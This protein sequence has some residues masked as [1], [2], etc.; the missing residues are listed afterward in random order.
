MGR[1]ASGKPFTTID[2]SGLGQFLNRLQRKIEA[3]NNTYANAPQSLELDYAKSQVAAVAAAVKALKEKILPEFASGKSPGILTWSSIKSTMEEV[4]K[5]YLSVFSTPE[6]AVIGAIKRNFDTLCQEA[7]KAG[8]IKKITP[9]TLEA[10]RLQFKQALRKAKIYEQALRIPGMDLESILKQVDNT[11]DEWDFSENTK[12]GDFRDAL[13]KALD[14]TFPYMFYVSHPMSYDLT[15]EFWYGLQTLPE[16]IDELFSFLN[17]DALTIKIPALFSATYTPGKEPE[18][19]YIFKIESHGLSSTFDLQFLLSSNR[20]M[21]DSAIKVGLKDYLERI[22]DTEEGIAEA[23]RQSD[24]Q[25]R[26]KKAKHA[27][28]DL[29]EDFNKQFTE[30]SKPLSLQEAAYARQVDVVHERIRQTEQLMALAQEFLKKLK[31]EMANVSVSGPADEEAIPEFFL[32]NNRLELVPARLMM[33]AEYAK[34]IKNIEEKQQSLQQLHSQL[35]DNIPVI[36]KAWHENELAFH[37]E[38]RDALGM[39]LEEMN[40]SLNQFDAYNPTLELPPDPDGQVLALKSE[41]EKLGGALEQLAR[42][43]ETVGKLAAIP[44]RDTGDLLAFY[45]ALNDEIKAIYKS[46]Q[47]VRAA[48]SERI[49]R[50]QHGLLSRCEKLAFQL[51]KAQ[52]ALAFRESMRSTNLEGIKQLLAQ[53]QKQL[54]DAEKQLKTF[55][56]DAIKTDKSISAAE[57]TKQQHEKM[58][59]ELQKNRNDQLELAKKSAARLAELIQNARGPVLSFDF[60]TPNEVSGFKLAVE[61]SGQTFKDAFNKYTEEP[62]AYPDTIASD[63]QVMS[64]IDRCFMSTKNS[65][66]FKAMMGIERFKGRFFDSEKVSFDALL[67]F[68]DASTQ[69][70]ESLWKFK[71]QQGN[72]DINSQAYQEVV[73]LFNSLL[74]RKRE[75][76]EKK[77][78]VRELALAWQP[79]DTDFVKE[80][81]HFDRINQSLSLV[82]Q[83]LAGSEE[84]LIK[85][86]KELAKLNK[87]KL[88]QDEGI[89]SSQEMIATLKPNVEIVGLI[90]QLTEGIT[91][92]G[93]A[94]RDKDAEAKIETLY[95]QYHK[96]SKVY[97]WLLEKLK[98]IPN[99]EDYVSNQQNINKQLAANLEQLQVL[100]RGLIKKQLESIQSTATVLQEKFAKDARASSTRE[101]ET[102]PERLSKA[103]SILFNFNVLFRDLLELQKAEKAFAEKIEALNDSEALKEYK[104][105]EP[106]KAVLEE[107]EASKQQ[108]L[109]DNKALLNEMADQLELYN[110]SLKFNYNSLAED[111]VQEEQR[112][113]IEAY[114]NTID[115]PLKAFDKTVSQS[116]FKDDLQESLD[117]VHQSISTLNKN[118]TDNKEVL[119]GTRQRIQQRVRSMDEFTQLFNG[120]KT[121]RAK[122][123][124]FKDSIDK[125]DARQREQYIDELHVKLNNFKQRGDLSSLD[126]L[127]QKAESG[128]AD[129]HGWTLRPM[130]RRLLVVLQESRQA[131]VEKQAGPVNDNDV[132]SKKVTKGD[133]QN[134]LDAL[135]SRI[136]AMG[137]YAQKLKDKRPEH[138][139]NAVTEVSSQLKKRLDDFVEDKLEGENQVTTE[140]LT[141]FTKEMRNILRSQDDTMHSERS[142]LAPIAANIVA[143]LF[144]LGI[145]LGIKLASSKLTQ[146]YAT[147]FMSKSQREKNVDDVDEA[148]T[149]LAAPAA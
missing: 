91:Q 53:K 57:S 143:G 75:S 149:Q 117:K 76:L 78:L 44:V 87:D 139:V 109:K 40:T 128:C 98:D 114:L 29:T 33:Q 101:S 81:D 80:K 93:E 82:S 79:L 108:L 66:N 144:T 3:L 34:A 103:S 10:F 1:R 59:P 19:H 60:R 7:C 5:K 35:N 86:E 15:T 111:N 106:L 112:K 43:K 92:L 73:F 133:V 4:S 88:K 47:D 146:G 68:L 24:K 105:E 90:I 141:S 126:E 138:V 6:H 71:Q 52:S 13:L 42:D 62:A 148:L 107:S 122:R 61:S 14:V 20:G 9:N 123:F 27:L 137:A 145:A 56:E 22:A 2:D 118:I 69:E 110:Q 64:E 94:I 129:F 67:T 17:P 125:R 46:Q 140:E 97:S 142:W 127:Y 11:V 83:S 18:R 130:L 41:L 132:P 74:V 99:A 65:V 31:Q 38:Q 36:H 49:D 63:R 58:I 28:H 25:G 12:A 102:V 37:Q 26:F 70:I 116:G 85:L 124:S 95:G 77:A 48:L 45:P 119:Q 134:A 51:E 30:V 50:L 100:A 39:T 72:L 23:K 115:A 131:L 16:T 135:Y 96:L 121:Q 55:S 104:K 113:A 84:E 89:I 21:A 54:V 8:K 120:Y 147:F 136:E 32:D